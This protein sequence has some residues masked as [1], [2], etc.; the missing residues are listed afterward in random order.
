VSA[1]VAYERLFDASANPYMVLDRELRYV[2]A[3][4]AYLEVT[5]VRDLASLVGRYIF[6][7]FPNDPEDPAN[8]PRRLVEDSLRK[9][10][11]SRK[12][13][14]LAYIPYLVDGRTRI[15]S[16]TH[17]PIL[18]DQGD[19][20][21][22]LQ[23]TQDVTELHRLAGPHEAASILTRAAT[24]Q[25]DLADLDDRLRAMHSMLDQAPGFVAFLRGPEHVFEYTNAA[26]DQ[27]I[28]RRVVGKRVTEALPDLDNQGYY[29]LLDQVY[30]SGEPFVGRG[31]RVEIAQT[32]ED[33]PV[34][35]YVD[36]LYQPIKAASGATI[37]I[38]VQG[39]DVTEQKRTSLRQ[40][41]L[42]RASECLAR[43]AQNLEP[44]LQDVAWA[45]TETIA[46]WA[47]VDLFDDAGASSRRISVAH[48]APERRALAD[49]LRRYSMPLPLSPGHVLHGLDA[50]P[51]LTSPFTDEALA[52]STSTPEH[53]AAARA[54]GFRSLIT[55]PLTHG[56]H[57][58]GALV[59]ATAESRR[60]FDHSDLPAMTELGRV[61]ATALDNAR[62]S[63][64]R[65]DLLAREHDARQRAEAANATKDEFLAML[66]HELRNP[67]APILTAVELLKSRDVAPREADI[68]E[69]QTQH[70][71]RLVDDLLDVSRIVH[72]KV[73]L[74]RTLVDLG[75]VAQRACE[76]ARPTI[77]QRGH[78]LAV[79]LAPDSLVVN[80]DE[81]RLVQV[82]SNL[83]INAARYTPAGGHI[84]VSARAE[85]SDAVV[86][87]RDNGV[88]LEPEML[89]RVFEMFVQGPRRVDRAEGGLGLGLTLVR[90]L[91]E[92]HDGR[93]EAASDGLG[94]GSTFTIRVPRVDAVAAA[95][96]PASPSKPPPLAEG[97]DILVVDDNVDAAE[98]LGELLSLHGHAVHVVHDGSE[99]LDRIVATPP[100]IPVIG[101]GL[102]GLAGCA[103]AEPVPAPS[104]SPPSPIARLTGYGSQSD[105]ERTREAGFS[106]HLTKPV[107]AAKL[108]ELLRR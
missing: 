33:K 51:I 87:V 54:I 10:L 13:D 84:I 48:A 21:W 95:R 78:T 96:S 23:H 64:E 22:I 24:V 104:R 47:V 4:R 8:E 20:Q 68:I 76:I 30:R 92:M 45:A 59:L 34:D 3:N 71:V 82:V 67:L 32:Q 26:Y 86:S 19:V 7:A 73:E 15:W 50:V 77:A 66:G 41:F 46:D 83:L 44:A 18:D 63:R 72:G 61:L 36:F 43:A 56:E 12:P 1:P 25:R 57:R 39:H 102:T 29:E 58:Y 27:L 5:G 93:V 62:L 89:T 69:R 101:P 16:A 91:V 107:D 60:M 52:R 17:T 31:M 74:R 65:D 55:V 94:K 103:P 42:T 105:R 75:A 108:L 85:S 88:G 38:L 100:E 2:T 97:R 106:A 11:S 40:Q 90:R 53:L 49:Q 80:G 35:V 70:M 98:M 9:V 79:D 6:D 28:G 14:V 99:A 37:G 81:A